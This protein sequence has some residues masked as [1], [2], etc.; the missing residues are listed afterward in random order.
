MGATAWSSLPRS[1][2]SDDGWEDIVA[3]SADDIA[4]ELGLSD[5]QGKRGPLIEGLSRTPT[6]RTDE[7][8]AAQISAAL[9]PELA[10]ELTSSFDDEPTRTEYE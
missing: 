6:P 9:P 7:D 3:P 2:V 10:N 5:E 1:T 4:E 8:L